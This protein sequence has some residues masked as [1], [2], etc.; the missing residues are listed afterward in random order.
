MF[1]GTPFEGS[2]KA[3]WAG[4]LAHMAKFFP[5]AGVTETLLDHLKSDSSELEVLGKEFKGWLASRQTPEERQV[6]I[7][8]FCEELPTMT[9]IADAGRIVSPESAQIG[10]EK[11]IPLSADHQ[12]ICKFDNFEDPKYKTVLATLRRWVDE[13]KRTSSEPKPEAVR[14]SH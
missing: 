2:N 13:I 1:L 7:A 11:V 8:C 6:H 12:G 4:L 10:N 9:A 5:K 14:N 3:K